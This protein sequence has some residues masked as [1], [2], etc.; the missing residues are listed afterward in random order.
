MNIAYWRT[1]DKV[2]AQAVVS[3]LTLKRLIKSIYYRS[4]DRNITKTTCHI[5][6]YLNLWLRQLRLSFFNNLIPRH[7]R[8][9]LDKLETIFRHIKHAKIRNN[10]V[11]DTR[12]RQG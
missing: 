7:T 4:D 9:K 2:S 5:R 10:P 8:S 6:E 11:Y 12:P 1:I 3:L